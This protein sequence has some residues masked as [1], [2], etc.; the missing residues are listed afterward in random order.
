MGAVAFSK[1]DRFNNAD[2]CRRTQKGYLA[3]TCLWGRDGGETG[4]LIKRKQYLGG[5]VMIRG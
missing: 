4:K 1:A 2:I 5:Q 3:W